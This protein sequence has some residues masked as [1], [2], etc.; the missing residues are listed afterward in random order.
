MDLTLASASTN[1]NISGEFKNVLDA[2]TSTSIFS[3][4][5]LFMDWLLIQMTTGVPYSRFNA[6]T[7]W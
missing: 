6:H 7:E 3:I 4:A 2:G 5:I 1:K